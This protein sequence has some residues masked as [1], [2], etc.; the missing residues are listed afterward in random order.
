MISYSAS[1][2]FKEALGEK[3]TFFL[4]YFQYAYIVFS[5]SFPCKACKCKWS[6]SSQLFFGDVCRIMIVWCFF[7]LSLSY[8][9]KS[10]CLICFPFKWCP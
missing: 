3:K 5:D 4:T 8:I 6:F 9:W 7:K 10:H 1:G 2:I